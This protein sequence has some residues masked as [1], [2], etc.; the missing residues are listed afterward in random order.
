[1]PYWDAFASPNLPVAASLP[2]IT[3]NTPSGNMTIANPLYSYVFHADEGGNPF[4]STNPVRGPDVQISD[5]RQM[6]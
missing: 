2:S 5:S 1:M 4:P 6:D 3:V